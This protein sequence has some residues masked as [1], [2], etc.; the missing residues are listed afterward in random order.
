MAITERMD[1]LRRVRAARRELATNILD[2][3]LQQE[4]YTNS[5]R[6]IAGTIRA[7]ESE[8]ALFA[9][10]FH[11]SMPQH[12]QRALAAEVRLWRILY[13]H[14]VSTPVAEEEYAR[15]CDRLRDPAQRLMRTLALEE[16]MLTNPL[17]DHYG[18][19]LDALHAGDA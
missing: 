11:E 3:I 9:D 17:V 14:L 1:H 8:P 19:A 5:P 13:D 2:T 16:E 12:L 4:F 6:S 15:L 10:Y 18:R 7:A